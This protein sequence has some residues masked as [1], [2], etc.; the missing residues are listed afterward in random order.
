[1][2]SRCANTQLDA[3]AAILA[4]GIVRID[5][6]EQRRREA[7]GKKL[8]VNAENRLENCSPIRPC[9][10]RTVA[11]ATEKSPKGAET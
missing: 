9:G 10:D 8:L 6:R 3:L 1:M 4:E 11:R 7:D 2:T 5:W